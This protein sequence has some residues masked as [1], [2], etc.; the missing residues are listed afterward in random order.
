MLVDDGRRVR[1]GEGVFVREPPRTLVG[2]D[3]AGTVIKLIL[4]DFGYGGEV[5]TNLPVT[6]I[7]GSYTW[8]DLAQTAEIVPY[9]TVNQ[10]LT[11]LLSLAN[12]EMTPIT[13]A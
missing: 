11:G 5:T 2:T 9:Q 8:D 12:S 13:A 6:F 3:Q 7:V 1:R 10:S 4:T